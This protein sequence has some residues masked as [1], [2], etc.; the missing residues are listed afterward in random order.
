MPYCLPPLQCH[1][2]GANDWLGA[3]SRLLFSIDMPGTPRRTHDEETCE[4]L[5]LRAGFLWCFHH[6]LP[7][8]LRTR[9]THGE[10]IVKL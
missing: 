8:M 7:Y 10:E 9:R 1:V 6:C 4:K 5:F 2:V 3:P